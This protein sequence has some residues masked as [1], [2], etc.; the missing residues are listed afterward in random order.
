MLN[1]YSL[2][3]VV[4]EL[5]DFCYEMIPNEVLKVYVNQ[6]SRSVLPSTLDGPGSSTVSRLD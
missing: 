4:G 1:L 5:G 3:K 6:T 2:W